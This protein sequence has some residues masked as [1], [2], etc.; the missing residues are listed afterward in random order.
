[1]L[2]TVFYI[3]VGIGGWDIDK[4]RAGGW[5]FNVSTSS[6]PWYKFYSY[7]GEFIR[8]FLILVVKKKKLT[9]LNLW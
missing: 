3:I 7:F 5:I 2:P 6:E 8:L 1:M 9:L 4:L